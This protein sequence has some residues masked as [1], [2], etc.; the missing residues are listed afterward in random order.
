M[1]LHRYLARRFSL[2]FVAILALFFALM[3]LIDLIEQARRFS[4]QASSFG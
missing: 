2:I 1:I 4:G 3:T